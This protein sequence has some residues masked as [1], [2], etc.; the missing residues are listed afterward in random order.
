MPSQ[1]PLLTSGQL[2][3]AVQGCV[4]LHFEYFQ[5]QRLHNFSG[6]HVPMFDHPCSKATCSYIKIEFLVFQCVCEKS[7]GG[8]L[9]R[10][11]HLDSLQSL[12]AGDK[13][14]SKF[15]V[16]WWVRDHFIFLFST[17]RL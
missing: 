5:E 6:Q 3:L 16:V 1:T 4:R 7:L 17:L 11:D 15:P 14:V 8:F 2:E 12:A 10:D 9:T 13:L